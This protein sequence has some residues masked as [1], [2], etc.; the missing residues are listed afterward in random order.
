MYAKRNFGGYLFGQDLQAEVPEM[1]PESEVYMEATQSLYAV[2]TDFVRHNLC[3]EGI[4]RIFPETGTDGGLLWVNVSP[5][6]LWFSF[7]G[8]TR[9]K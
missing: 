2:W 6:N 7:I 1:T 4:G 9:K 5:F 3:Y 8:I